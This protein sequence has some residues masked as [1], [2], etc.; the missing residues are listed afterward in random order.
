MSHTE[1]NAK[2][3]QRMAKSDR[4]MMGI[5][6]ESYDKNGLEI[7]GKMTGKVGFRGPVVC[8][9]CFSLR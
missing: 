8:C 2:S 5:L 7:M 6:R 3:S 4:V 9:C 1:R